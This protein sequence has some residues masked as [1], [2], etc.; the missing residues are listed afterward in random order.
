MI[1]GMWHEQGCQD[2]LLDALMILAGG[3][4]DPWKSLVLSIMVMQTTITV[5]GDVLHMASIRCRC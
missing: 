1:G 3:G 2:N 5:W 4:C